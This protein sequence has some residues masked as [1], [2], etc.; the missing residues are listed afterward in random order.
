MI[1]VDADVRRADGVALVTGVLA[2]DGDRERTVRLRATVPVMPPRR[3]GVPERGWD[4]RTLTV[5]LPPAASRGVGFATEDPSVTPEDP[6]IELVDRAV[7]D[8]AEP[9]ELDTPAGLVRSLGES[10][11]PADAVPRGGRE[12][13]A[14]GEGR[15]TTAGAGERGGATTG[16]ESATA[17]RGV[18]DAEAEVDAEAK[19]E[20]G[21]EADAE[22]DDHPEPSPPSA[23]WE[24]VG[25][26]RGVEGR[27]DDG[28]AGGGPRDDG[29]PLVNEPRASDRNDSSAPYGGDSSAPCGDDVPGPVADWLASVERRCDRVERTSDDVPLSAA[30]A[31]VDAA[32]GLDGLTADLE[33]LAADARRLR[34]LADRAETLAAR[35]E[36]ADLPVADLEALA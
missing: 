11:P 32:G 3:R 34:A 23:D 7:D 27:S 15:G 4:D 12:T 26:E 19:A 24:W 1:T 36:A 30:T 8:P 33:R 22:T 18:V 2:N 35:A 31:T 16:T 13:R 29:T 5:R 14:A 17:S 10:S 28:P 25:E 6:P 20:T 9:G 21:M